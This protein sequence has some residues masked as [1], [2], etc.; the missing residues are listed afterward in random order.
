MKIRLKCLSLSSE[1]KTTV[2]CPATEKH[3]K[4]YQRQESFLVEETGSDYQSITLPYIQKQSFSV[5]VSVP[6]SSGPR[7]ALYD[8]WTYSYLEVNFKNNSSHLCL[9]PVGTQ[10]PGEKS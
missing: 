8:L 10:H 5:Q 1:I 7:Y 6:K 4:K 2:V 9:V 3:I